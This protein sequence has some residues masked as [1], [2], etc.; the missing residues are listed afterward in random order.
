M[1]LYL[2]QIIQ[3][4][5]KVENGQIK[6]LLLYG[7]D[8]GYID[9]VCK[10]LVKKFD[11]LKT[12]IEYSEIKN[13]SLET[14]V[15]TQ[16][17]FMQKQLII[18][19]SVGESIDKSLKLALG[20]DSLHFL[21]FIADELSAASSIRKFFE[22]ETYLASLACYHD[23]EHKITKIILQK[24]NSVGKVISEDTVNYLTAR[25]K[26]DHQTLVNEI[27]KLIY[28]T[29]DK[30][31]ITLDD[32]LAVVSDDFTGNGDNLCV[33]FS[34]GNLDNFLQEFTKLKQQNI[35]EV[36]I[37]RALIRYYLNLYTVLNKL[38]MGVNIDMAIKSLSPPIF[39][40]YVPSFKQALN[41][42]NLENCIKTLKHLEQ[43]EIDYKLNPAGFDI[44]QQV[45]VKTY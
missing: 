35:N 37:I 32:A 19:R 9:K 29:F 4:L 30:D 31:Q 11:L 24:C 1:K 2:S 33:Y 7:P 45:Y 44:Y 26:G 15:N 5:D 8:K 14:L 38:A 20:K 18:V 27:N 40:K 23:D 25:L 12:S 42:V 16:N 41:K 10:T 34:S 28:F 39:Y 22:T 21:V 43:A 3:L 17:F 36:L 13:R 6:A